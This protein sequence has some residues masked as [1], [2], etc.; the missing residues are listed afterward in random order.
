MVQKRRAQASGA[1]SVIGLMLLLFIFYI[2]FIP[3]E[4]R[5]ELLGDKETAAA[6]GT[7][8]G[9][10]QQEAD[11]VN[12]L[13]RASPGKIAFTEDVKVEHS[14]PNLWLAESKDAKVIDSYNPMAVRRGWFVNEVARLP[15]TIGNLADTFNAALIFSAPSREGLLIIKLNDNIVFEGEL[16]SANAAPVMLKKDLLQK[17]N[18]IEISVAGVGLRFWD[19]N[20]YQLTGIQVIGDVTDWQRQQATNIF[21]VAQEE[22]NSIKTSRLEFS[23]VCDQETTGVLGIYFNE[24]NVYSAVPDC[25]SM[26]KFDIFPADFAVGKNTVLFKITEGSY[27]L[28]QIKIVNTLKE[29]KAFV[30]YF[31][32]SGENYTDI[33]SRVV[34]AWLNITFVDDDLAKQAIANVNGRYSYIDQETPTY[35]KDISEYIVEGNNY[36]SLTPETELNVVKMDIYAE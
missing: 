21:T 10:G 9:A 31:Y 16:A 20:E 5:Q 30:T 29:P 25:D 27:L 35:L 14:V 18:I 2:I 11:N 32:V 13:M 7:G 8:A 1:A 4:T 22:F 23:P 36:V 12:Y 28:D 34:N 24:K 3:A 26:N 6:A 17:D 33:S 19:V 15:F